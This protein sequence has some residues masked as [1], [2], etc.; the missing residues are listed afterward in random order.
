MAVT[1]S[2]GYGGVVGKNRAFSLQERLLDWWLFSFFFQMR[3]S[4]ISPL[5]ELIMVVRTARSSK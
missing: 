4:F 1:T 3:Y 5:R 2:G